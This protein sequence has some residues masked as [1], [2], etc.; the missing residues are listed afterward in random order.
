MPEPLPMKESAKEAD[1]VEA[2]TDPVVTNET[3][4]DAEAAPDK[5][6]RA[7]G[8]A[9]HP[10]LVLLGRACL[11]IIKHGLRGTCFINPVEART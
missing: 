9:A 5:A 8:K 3:I 6:A 7:N 1:A 10:P 4:P 11:S 2:Q